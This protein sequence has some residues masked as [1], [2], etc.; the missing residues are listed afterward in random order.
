MSST[1]IQRRRRAQLDAALAP[2]QGL[3]RPPRRGWVRAI[4]GALGMTMRQLADR[5]GAAS[6]SSVTQIELGEV[7]GG[8]S[9]RRL[10][11]AADAL[12]CELV[13]ALVPRTGSLAETIQAQARHVARQSLVQADRHMALED[14]AVS[15]ESLE[16]LVAELARD[17]ENGPLARLWDE[18]P[19]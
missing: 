3:A 4:R 16:Q 19:K 10:R 2:F 15:A 13:Y 5:L 1:A 14:Q 8:L 6:V 9:I 17:L 18:L 11:A 7:E 12:D